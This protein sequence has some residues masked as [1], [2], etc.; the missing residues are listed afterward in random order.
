MDSTISLNNN[1]FS[2]STFEQNI[3]K[4]QLR[5]LLLENL[6][7]I[8]RE[9]RR[10]VLTKS[11]GLHE[12]QRSNQIDQLYNCV[13]ESL[14]CNEF[15]TLQTWRGQ[16]SIQ[17]F[18]RVIIVNKYID[19]CRKVEGSTAMTRLFKLYGAKA[20]QIYLWHF[21]QHL[22]ENQ[23]LKNLQMMGQPLPTL[24]LQAMLQQMKVALTNLP[25]F[26]GEVSIE[27]VELQ[28][29]Q[30]MP[31]RASIQKEQTQL[32]QQALEALDAED[33]LILV[34]RHVDGLKPAEIAMTLH[35]TEK[36]ISNRIYRS[37]QRCK[38]Y[39]EAKGAKLEDF[40]E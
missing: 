5:Q 34:Y 4:E 23:I 27:G 37:L 35:K 38:T 16:S 11:R 8:E 13:L 21:E 40:L 14:S 18:L 39:L 32:L 29:T 24:E 22:D 33:R 1:G 26:T 19:T 17:G 6:S 28:A 10:V 36:Y 12:I 9:C 3:V 30:P 2:V 31:D 25:R 15:A 20:K 7:F